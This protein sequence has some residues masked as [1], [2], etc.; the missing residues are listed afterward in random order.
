MS[1]VT[2][3]MCNSSHLNHF[4]EPIGSKTEQQVSYLALLGWVIEGIHLLLVYIYSS[5]EV[6]ALKTHV[7]AVAL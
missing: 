3:E 6:Y 2:G 7:L 4:T 1:H 5:D